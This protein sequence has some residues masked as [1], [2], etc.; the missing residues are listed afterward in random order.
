MAGV[1]GGWSVRANVFD[2]DDLL[3]CEVTAPLRERLVLELDR[4]D[5]GALVLADRPDHVDR[6]AVAGVGVR[7][8][9]NFSRPERTL[10]RS[11]ISVGVASPMSGRPYAD[12]TRGPVMYAA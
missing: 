3:A 11:A 6:R 10:A 4:G 2:V 9:R 7:D 8:Q 5:A 1:D 12:A